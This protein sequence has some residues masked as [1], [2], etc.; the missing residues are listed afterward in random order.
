MP[1]RRRHRSPKRGSSEVSEAVVRESLDATGA[2]A[3]R[4]PRITQQFQPVWVRLTCQQL[5]RSLA[6]S[7]G[8]V[9][10]QVTA[11]VQEEME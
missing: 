6:D 8:V 1:L 11:V 3:L 5:R 2:S 7:T 10:A 4:E 9:I